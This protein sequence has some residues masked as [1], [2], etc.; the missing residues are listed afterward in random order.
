[1]DRHTRKQSESGTSQLHMKSNTP[2]S[3]QQLTSKPLQQLRTKHETSKSKHR[4]H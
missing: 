1:M 4:E 3:Q 2:P